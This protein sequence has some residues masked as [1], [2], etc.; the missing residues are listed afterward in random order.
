M[1]IGRL[2]KNAK[3]I[4]LISLTVLLLLSANSIKSMQVFDREIIDNPEVAKYLHQMLQAGDK[5]I[6]VL[7][8]DYPLEY[9]LREL[10][11]DIDFPRGEK[12]GKKRFILI[13]NSHTGPDLPTMIENELS[14]FLYLSKPI[15]LK[16]FNYTDLFEVKTE[17][18]AGITVSP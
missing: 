11:V 17:E 12:S 7:P 5:I 9:Y 8:L 13:V 18:P 14:G 2:V 3:H 10:E 4:L 16:S 6:A 1:F 15:L